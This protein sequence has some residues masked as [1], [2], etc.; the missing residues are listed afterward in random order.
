MKIDK[1]QSDLIEKNLQ[2][3]SKL[4]SLD[5]EK[6][7]IN[8]SKN[9]LKSNFNKTI[10]LPN[11]N[12]E[13]EHFEISTTKLLSKKLSAK[14][15]D[16]KTFVGVSK[17]RKNVKARITISNK[18]LSYWLRIPNSDD[19]FFQPVRNKKDIHYGY[20]NSYFINNNSLNCKTEL[21]KN[22]LFNSNFLNEKK[23]VNE[24]I[25]RTFRIAIM[26]TGEYTSFWGD[27][28]D[29][30]GDNSE[31]AYRAV[32]NT[33]NRVNEIYENE[34]Q[35][36][37]ELISDSS[38]LFSDSTVDPFTSSLNDEAQSA[39]DS[40]VG[41]ENYDLGHLF[42]YGQSDGD[43]GCVGC[44]CTAG[45]KGRAYSIHPF[46]D[47]DGGVF[48]NDYFDLD[49]V[50]HEIG[51][52]FGAYHTF[53]F[54][55]E[56][57]GSNVEPGSGST[58][59][60]YAG[61]TGEDDVQAHGDPY[62]HYVSIKE[63]NNYVSNLSCS[64]STSSINNNVYNIDGGK[65]YNIPKGTAYK[66]SPLVDEPIPD[67]INFNWEQLDS[68]QIG[69][70][71][72]G[73]LN[74]AGPIARSI[75]PSTKKTRYIPNI[76]RII[77]GNLTQT[78]PS[79]GSAW[80]TVTDVGRV[81]NWGITLRDLRD[82]N[83][84]LISQ[85]NM[86]IN[87]SSNSGPFVISS[88][89]SS[90]IIWEAGSKKIITW[91]VANT[92]KSPIDTETVTIFLSEDGGYNYPIKLIENT[93]NDGEEEII[94]P[95]SISSKNCRI[96]I[97]ADNS[98][99]FAIN[100]NDF[101]IKQLPFVI[102]YNNNNIDICSKNE[103]TID[104]KLNRFLNYEKSI[105]LSI[106]GP[107]ELL[108]SSFSKEVFFLE[109]SEGE[110][111]LSGLN[112]LSPG[113]YEFNMIAESENNSYSYSF[114]INYQN[115]ILDLPN[116][117]SPENNSEKLNLFP[118][119]IWEQND[120]VGQFRLQVSKDDDFENLELDE[121]LFKNSYQLYNLK[122]DQL[123][124]WRVQPINVCG[125]GDFSNYNI[126]KTDKTSCIYFN[127]S[128][129]PIDLNDANSN[130]TG[131]TISEV[132]VPYDASIVDLKVLVNIEHSWL[133]DLTLYLE[134]PDGVKIILSKQIGGS[135]NNYSETLFD[136]DSNNNIFNA[137]P[138]FSGPY[139]PVQ[140]L[141][142]FYNKNAFGKWKLIVEDSFQED[143]GSINGFSIEICL[144]GT[145]LPN[146]DEDSIVDE[147]DNCPN[148]SNQD[149]LDS[150]GN[151][152]G[153][154]CDIFSEQNILLSKSNS[155]C[156][157]KNNG[158]IQ[159][160]VIADYEYKMIINSDNGF[161]RDLNFD[162]SG[163]IIENLSPGKYSICITSNSFPN[164][165]SCYETTI[166]EPELNVQL[167][168]NVND[169]ILNLNLSG[170]NN[171]IVSINDEIFYYKNSGNYKLDLLK[172]INYLKVE[173]ENQCQSFYE[174]WISLDNI[175]KIFP[176]PVKNKT[177]VLLPAN[178]YFNLSLF[179]AS[180]NL[181]WDNCSPEINIDSSVEIDMNGFIPGLYLLEIKNQ[182]LI[183]TFKIIKE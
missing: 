126:F 57:A 183:Q 148:I 65:D 9:T 169:R 167:F 66:L 4:Y 39:M 108:N 26:G 93:P 181:L 133:E 131:I 74:V 164:Y 113:I 42:D 38:L 157:S 174:D 136:Q 23:S 32:V 81:L 116:L 161:Y 7:K 89:N 69:S 47:N 155:T 19:Y 124:Y 45:V 110:L 71:N 180:G 92:N 128:D 28:D 129:L 13:Y 121:I 158:K 46:E 99:Y 112:N 53:A 67:Q 127:S 12:G 3:N 10:Y 37:L 56:N 43:A 21:F 1:V 159:I 60:G 139:M 18:G 48:R 134:S 25:L 96:K 6:F 44:V 59:M 24:N 166:N 176:N 130:S 182:E 61:I 58:I 118:E 50:A 79:R 35:I 80:E 114:K 77:S 120:N 68:G 115:E 83:Q 14:Y 132:S 54:Q 178:D 95:S 91:D 76:E 49:Y 29:S 107:L 177:T 152:I 27:N 82:P 73:P 52:Q 162:L 175:V 2:N 179:N 170:S 72:F 104:F 154:A 163:L 140:S 138:P 142:T 20:L 103:V 151:G 63:I 31:D 160:E 119:L 156:K 153:D 147:Q 55:S 64:I 15:Q 122:S 165:Q 123:Y 34:L 41:N 171:Y 173:T 144:L 100:R 135:G 84:G 137:S 17:K 105:N 86:K 87:V 40:I 106:E 94:V 11:E 90:N 125:L 102:N 70:S 75:L 85:D 101:E 30:N 8:F 150:N 62:F 98:I 172:K 146:S 145:P 51:H 97:K 88:Q 141:E 33:I 149:Q 168:V 109:D 78:N 143:T 117:V 36:K 22:K 16:I 5:K 111:V